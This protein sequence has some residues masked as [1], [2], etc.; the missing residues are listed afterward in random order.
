MTRFEELDKQLAIR[1][2][3]YDRGSEEF[4]DG[5]KR[6]HWKEV[7]ALVPGFTL[8]ELASYVDDQHDR[9]WP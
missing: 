3:N 2:W 1:G 8:D 4:R 7:A 5:K 9:K 6:L